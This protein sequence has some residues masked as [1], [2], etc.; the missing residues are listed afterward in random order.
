MQL[1]YALLERRNFSGGHGEDW[2]ETM[3]TPLNANQDKDEESLTKVVFQGVKDAID[4]YMDDYDGEPFNVVKLGD[5]APV[6]GYL[7]TCGE[8]WT[9]ITIATMNR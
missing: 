2:I 1:N 6:A 9:E 3:F 4:S 8:F 5:H 7:V